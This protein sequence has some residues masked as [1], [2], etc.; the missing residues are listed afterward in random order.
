MAERSRQLSFDLPIDPQ[1]GIDDFLVGASNEDAFSTITGWPD[2]PSRRLHLSGPH[3]SGKSHLAATWAR[4]VGAHVI[5]ATSVTESAVPNLS[6]SGSLV[7]EDLDRGELDEHALF[8]LVNVLLEQDGYLLVTSAVP[9]DRCGLRLADLR[10][11]LRLAPT[12]TLG[13]PDDALLKA[14]LVKLFI[15]R[16]LVIDAS[17]V[18]FVAAR[19]E[20]SFEAAARV[21]AELD[22]EALSRGRRITRPIAANILPHD[23]EQ[24]AADEG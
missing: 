17:V 3:G 10:S 22:R 21:V 12:V 24:V 20:R 5:A 2:W 9:I 11:R 19:I 23:G 18:A 6:V 15:D 7:L 1:L 4:R 14:V 8:H 13:E 16:Q